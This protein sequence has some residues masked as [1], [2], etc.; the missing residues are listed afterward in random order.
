MVKGRKGNEETIKKF[1]ARALKNKNFDIY[2]SSGKPSPSK[3]V[4]LLKKETGVTITRQTMS[5]YLLDDLSPYLAEVD[6]SQNNKIK[7]ITEAMNIAKNIY[8]SDDT[9]AGDKTKALNSWKALNQ[10]LIDYEKHLRDLAMRKMEAQKPNYLIKIE[11][12]CGEYTCPE[13]KYACYIEYDDER[14]CWIKVGDR[15][16][17]IVDIEENE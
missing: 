2:S 7:E 6:F 13:C 3:L 1:L 5:K 10:Q 17:E 14:K 4:E 16:D 11:A 9:R 15:K 12:A 8:N